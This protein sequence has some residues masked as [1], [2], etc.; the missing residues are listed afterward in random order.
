M[1]KILENK[2]SVSLGG[3][4]RSL[5]FTDIFFYRLRSPN[6]G[7]NFFT[8]IFY[9]P[10]MRKEKTKSTKHHEEELV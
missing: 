4:D 6:Y 7:S 9:D 2:I 5:N 3:F 8:K 1:S 10:K